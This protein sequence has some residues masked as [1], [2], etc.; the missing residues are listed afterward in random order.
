[1]NRTRLIN[2]KLFLLKKINLFKKKQMFLR[3]QVKINF[4]ENPEIAS[5]NKIIMQAYE[6]LFNLTVLF[7]SKQ[8]FLTKRKFIFSKS[9]EL[10][11]LPN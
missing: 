5:T 3:E 6:N 10:K 8:K 2:I 9:M 7:K 1:M 4:V 11:K